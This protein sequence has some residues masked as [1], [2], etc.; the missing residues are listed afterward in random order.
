MS[1]EGIHLRDTKTLL[2]PYEQNEQDVDRRSRSERTIHFL[3]S[4]Q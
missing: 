4:F 3:Q 1:A 2:Y